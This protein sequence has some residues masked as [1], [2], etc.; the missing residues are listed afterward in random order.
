LSA[1]D[2]TEGETYEGIISSAFI[3]YFNY[4]TGQVQ[5]AD[6]EGTIST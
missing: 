4:S 5:E 3:D 2:G 1:D 6:V